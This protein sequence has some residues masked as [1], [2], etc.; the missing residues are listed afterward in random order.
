MK[1]VALG[2]ITLATVDEGRGPTLL[3]VHGLPLDHFMWAEQIQ[4]FRGY[5]RVIAP[6]LCGF[7]ASDVREGTVTMAQM[8]DDL[9]ALL[10]ALGVTE[11]VVF[12]GLSMGGYV[13]WQFWRRHGQ[14]LAGLVLCDTRAAA[15]SAAAARDRELTAQKALD[16]GMSVIAEAMLPRL[17]APSTLTD[18]LAVTEHV[19]RMILQTDPRG[20]AAAVRGIAVRPDATPWLSEV[21]VPTLALAGA[22]DAISPPD[23]MR[24]FAEQMPQA[25][26]VEIADAGHLAPLE[27]PQA[28]NL[29]LGEYLGKRT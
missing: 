28:V 6:D 13:G 22:A 29:A 17:V 9:A 11:P 21:D 12:C 14:R 10:D 3:L 5:C 23:E 20:F 1:R 25:R 24:Q 18:R 26:F 27:Q 4:A 19:R 8:A 2:D 16:Q 15:D 7:G